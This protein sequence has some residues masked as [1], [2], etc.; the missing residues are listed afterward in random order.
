MQLTARVKVIC[1][2]TNRPEI[3]RQPGNTDI[4]CTLLQTAD[5][6][7]RDR[8]HG[9]LLS[10]FRPPSLVLVGVMNTHT[11]TLTCTTP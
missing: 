10:R 3:R 9:F 11:Y 5:R 8:R 6:T 4:V 7:L 2:Y 1:F